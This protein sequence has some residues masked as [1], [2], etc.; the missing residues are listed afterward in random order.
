MFV[1]RSYGSRL[2]IALALLACI[3]A[4]I[5]D[6]TAIS[7][8][9]VVELPG[10]T[11]VGCL[12]P[13]SSGA[14]LI[15]AATEFEA[16]VRAS[17]D[18]GKSWVGESTLVPVQNGS[19]NPVTHLVEVNNK[20]YALAN[21]S[22]DLFR[23]SND[24][25]FMNTGSTGYTIAFRSSKLVHTG[26]HFVIA[27]KVF[28]TPDPVLIASVD[29]ISWNLMTN[30]LGTLRPTMLTPL[31]GIGFVSAL[32]TP[33]GDDSKLVYGSPF[34]LE[35]VSVQP[36]GLSGDAGALVQST[37]FHALHGMGN[38]LRLLGLRPT[39]WQYDQV[40]ASFVSTPAPFEEGDFLYGATVMGE[41]SLYAV[42]HADNSQ[43]FV[44]KDF[45]DSVICRTP[46]PAGLAFY[47][48]RLESVTESLS[49][50]V[51][52]S[53]ERYETPLVLLRLL[54]DEAVPVDSVESVGSLKSRY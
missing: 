31:P 23:A 43:E 40:S 50:A 8:V 45:G 7:I 49:L 14:V 44:Y 53:D 18:L 3:N 36:L 2:L 22:D 38:S 15:G 13:L 27:R 41:G 11:S 10:L 26:S 42:R 46:L 17:E 5:A 24:L 52:R 16:V 20:V 37:P 47:D 1:P 21:S 6:G 34:A 33:S 54:L 39:S 32:A 19:G 4:S 35:A 51:V 28:E 25:N 29:G 48:R 9:D 30:S 12:A